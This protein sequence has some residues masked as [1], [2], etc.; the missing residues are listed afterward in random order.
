M[1]DSKGENEMYNSTQRDSDEWTLDEAE[2]LVDQSSM[3]MQDPSFSKPKDGTHESQPLPEELG[4]G[5]DRN[6]NST[7]HSQDAEDAAAVPAA[8]NASSTSCC[9]IGNEEPSNDWTEWK[10]VLQSCKNKPPNW[11]CLLL[12]KANMLH[13]TSE[14]LEDTDVDQ[15]ESYQAAIT[16]IAL[17][18]SSLQPTRQQW[19]Q[20]TMLILANLNINKCSW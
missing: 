6:S 17:L 4:D 20:D 16:H 18:C 14:G 10:R 2:L 11:L 9:T 3:E 5:D 1:A 12:R 7:A 15:C 19:M 13:R 8:E